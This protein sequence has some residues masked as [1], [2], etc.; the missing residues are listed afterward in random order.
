MLLHFNTIPDPIQKQIYKAIE[1][2][3]TIMP[4]VQKLTKMEVI[5]EGTDWLQKKGTAA[6]GGYNPFAGLKTPET[7]VQADSK[8]TKELF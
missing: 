5:L 6:P 3:L 1:S 8:I 4:I 7:K 2:D